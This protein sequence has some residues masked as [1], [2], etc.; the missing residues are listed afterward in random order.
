MNP[1]GCRTHR[2]R[3]VLEK[4]DDV[5]VR[6][7]F[8]LENLRNRKARLLPNFGSVFFRNLAELGHCLASQ[9]FNLEPDLVFP[10]VRPDL[11]HLRPGITINHAAKIKGSSKTKSCLLISL[12]PRCQ[13]S[14]ALGKYVAKARC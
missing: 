9:D 5:V 12:T 8:D 14:G 11:A 6:P 1:A 4:G 10:F 3:D 7:L 2:R 13:C